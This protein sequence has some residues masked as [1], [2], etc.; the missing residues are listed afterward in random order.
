MHPLLGA[1]LRRF[2]P[3]WPAKLE[4]TSGRPTYL[5]TEAICGEITFQ[6]TAYPSN[7]DWWQSDRE[8]ARSELDIVLAEGGLYRLLIENNVYFIEGEYD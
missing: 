7:G 3:P 2:R 6:G 8:W 4:F 1:P 5:W